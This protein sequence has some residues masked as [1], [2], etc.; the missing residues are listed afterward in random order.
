MQADNTAIIK[1]IESHVGKW[2]LALP[3][4]EG[5][6]IVRAPV[7]TLC[8]EPGS[9]GCQVAQAVAD[10]LGFGLYNRDIIKAIAKSMK[11][12]SDR[13]AMLEKERLSGIEDFIACLIEEKYCHNDIYMEHL[14]KVVRVIAARGNAVIVGRG[15]NFI[16]PF[17]N[18]FAARIIAP[19]EIRVTNIMRAFGAEAE[20]ARQRITRREARRR[21][22]IRQAFNKDIR[23]PS[24]YDITLNTA[25]L[26]VPA[27]ATAIVTAAVSSKNAPGVA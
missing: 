22:F 6:A 1:F 8:M 25:R 24:H 26:S 2:S 15:A 7:I 21:A 3:E 20:N 18:R 5:Q 16:L 11:I 10:Q 12:G 13:I 14:V 4:K 27:A 23:N 9:H 17:E 19:A